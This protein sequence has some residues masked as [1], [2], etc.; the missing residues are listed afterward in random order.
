MTI[1]LD[2]SGLTIEKLVKIARYGEKAEIHFLPHLL[3]FLRPVVQLTDR[4]AG[5]L[6][7]TGFTFLDVLEYLAVLIQMKKLAPDLHKTSRC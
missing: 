7:E 5:G 4:I 3:V 6:I 1:A 2:G